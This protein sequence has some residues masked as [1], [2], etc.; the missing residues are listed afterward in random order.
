MNPKLSEGRR[1]MKAVP[2]LT[3]LVERILPLL[4]GQTTV[5]CLNYANAG[6]W[7]SLVCRH[8]TVQSNAWRRTKFA[9]HLDFRRQEATRP[10]AYKQFVL[11]YLLWMLNGLTFG[12]DLQAVLSTKPEHEAC[13][14]IMNYGMKMLE[15]VINL[16]IVGPRVLRYLLYQVSKKLLKIG[17]EM[18]AI[19]LHTYIADVG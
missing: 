10:R 11:L 9:I 1:S 8:L 16:S 3:D 15:K 13:H 17:K 6:Q 2:P 19:F 14:L 5:D 4:N 7:K 12:G 18:G